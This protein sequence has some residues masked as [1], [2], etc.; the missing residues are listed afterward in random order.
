MLFDMTNHEISAPM[1]LS[2]S[3]RT[4]GYVRGSFS[5]G[6]R[7][8]VAIGSGGGAGPVTLGKLTALQ[9][10]GVLDQVDEIHAI[11]VGAINA[12]AL[13]A[14][15]GE[16]ALSGYMEMTDK[17]FIKKWRLLRVVDMRILERV[18]RRSDGL[19]QQKVAESEIPLHVGVT[20]LTGGLKPVSINLT[21]QDPE[22]VIG[23]LM[24]G[25]HLGIAAGPAPKDRHGDVYADGGFSHLSAIDMA[26]KVCTDII[27]L[28]NQPYE[29]DVYKG[30]QV[31]LMG[32][33]L[34][35]Y[36]RH[37]I[38]AFRRVVRSQIESRRPI[39]DGDFSYN[40]ANVT[41]FFPPRP[42]TPE[43]ALPTLFNTDPRRIDAGFRIGSMHAL[44]KIASYFPV[45]QPVV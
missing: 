34:S 29:P 23:W 7:L 9:K 22:D 5:D 37:A 1:A 32:A 2:V 31:A 28:S 6:R 13:L 41:A 42:T 20:R 25:A 10:T 21:E 15:Q 3:R 4:N 16:L 17:G 45:P 26:A 18:L 24:S 36:D 8:G 14:G 33:G 11:S 30:W 40:G 44:N 43:D 39:C 19:D 27:Y 12:A 38:P 35:L